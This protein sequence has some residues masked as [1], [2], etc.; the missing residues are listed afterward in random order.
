MSSGWVAKKINNLRH[1]KW[2]HCLMRRH[3]TPMV[4][5]RY[6]MADDLLVTRE[7]L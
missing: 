2:P 6:S 4:T 7:I 3:G 5:R 1:C